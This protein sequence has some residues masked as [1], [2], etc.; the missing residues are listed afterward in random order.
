MKKTQKK[1][2]FIRFSKKQW[3][4]FAVPF[5]LLACYLLF[6]TFAVTQSG[7]YVNLTW[8]DTGSDKGFFNIDHNLTIQK[9]TPDSHYFWSHQFGFKPP[10][11]GGYMGLQSG[12]SRVDGSWGKTAVFSIF[13][14][15]TFANSAGCHSETTGFDGGG[16]NAGGTSCRIPY[17]WVEGRTYRIRIWTTGSDSTGTYWGSWVLDTATNK[18][19]EIGNIKVPASWGWLSSWSSMWSEYFGGQKDS[20]DKYPY[21]KVLFSAP[22]ANGGAI[23]PLRSSPSI[24]SNADCKYGK[25][26]ASGDGF[27][28][29]MGNPNYSVPSSYQTQTSPE[30]SSQ[31]TPSPSSTPSQPSQTPPPRPSCKTYVLRRCVL[32]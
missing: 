5:A 11:D 2:N 22:T 30:P 16:S 23:K 18:E 27:I 3:L 28:E 7:T 21:S 9:V 13:G 31:P 4:L 26:T 8:Q 12:G 1:L 17:E 6:V 19:T 32:R 24:S 15:G 29:E 10:G 25:I 20:C 14:Q